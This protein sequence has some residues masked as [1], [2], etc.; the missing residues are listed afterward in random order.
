[1]ELKT[2]HFCNS[3]LIFNTV[4]QTTNARHKSKIER[5]VKKLTITI[6]NQYKKRFNEKIISF[7]ALTSITATLYH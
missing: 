3:N 6:G 4:L 2:S 1:M 7:C 5:F